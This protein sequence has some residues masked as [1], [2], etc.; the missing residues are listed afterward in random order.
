[1]FLN[2]NF[3]AIF[4]SLCFVGIVVFLS[5]NSVHDESVHYSSLRATDSGHFLHFGGAVRA[6]YFSVEDSKMSDNQFRFAAV[7][8]LDQL[9][10]MPGEKPKF[11][12]ILQP[13][14]ISRDAGSNTYSIH[15]DDTRKLVS[16]HNEAGRGMELSEL[17]VYQDRLLG[18]YF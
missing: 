14:H 7:T 2:R 5:S 15:F 1:M 9:S 10:R 8:D 6:G 11:Y 4:V 12:S 16:K 3:K 17:T 13:G 18:E